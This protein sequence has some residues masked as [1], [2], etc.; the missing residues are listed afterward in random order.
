MSDAGLFVLGVLIGLVAS[1]LAWALFV[2]LP[3]G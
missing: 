3:L 1:K 2:S